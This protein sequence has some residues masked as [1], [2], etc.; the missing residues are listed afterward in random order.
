MKLNPITLILLT[1]GSLVATAS[2]QNRSPQLRPFVS[3]VENGVQELDATR[4][5]LLPGS[6]VPGA[7]PAFKAHDVG[8]AD[9]I[10][11]RP[12]YDVHHERY[13]VYWQVRKGSMDSK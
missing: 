12:L 1:L 2:A 11:F 5:R 9:G 7:V 10:I 13:S 3:V 4:V 6:P 8:A